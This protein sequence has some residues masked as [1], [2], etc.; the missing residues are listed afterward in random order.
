MRI[1]NE[2]EGVNDM[3]K[4]IIIMCIALISIGVIGFLLWGQSTSAEPLTEEEVQQLA[5]ERYGGEVTDIQLVNNEFHI[6]LTLPTGTYELKVDRMTGD[7][8]SMQQTNA[9][10]V[11]EELTEKDVRKV[12]SD[13][14]SGEI[15]DIK[16]KS[17]E[18][19]TYFEVDVESKE[20]KT[21]LKIDAKTGETID[22]NEVKKKQETSKD[23]ES[24]KEKDSDQSEI[25]KSDENEKN[26][27]EQNAQKDEKKDESAAQKHG[28]G[29]TEAD[30]MYIALETVDPKRIGEIDDVDLEEVNGEIYYFV[31]VEFDSGEEALVQINAIT[32]E[33]KTINW[34][35]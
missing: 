26:K 7:V 21:T 25:E 29:I 8:V 28:S 27:N 30:A 12:V 34:D 10:E 2:K 22:K 4:Q 18:K 19:Q 17:D 1:C 32:G 13:K 6:N 5:D 24:K 20:T 31:E 16:K 11:K 14:E 3:K 9:V 15:K 33:V 35:D 23:S